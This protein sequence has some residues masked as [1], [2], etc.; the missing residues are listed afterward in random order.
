MSENTT[1]KLAAALKLKHEPARETREVVVTGLQIHAGDV[2]AATG[3]RV[4]SARSGSSK[5]I[6]KLEGKKTEHRMGID[7][8]VTVL[9]DVE[10]DE[11]REAGKA[12][13]HEFFAA[14]FLSG[15]VG[16][17]EAARNALFERLQE[18]QGAWRLVDLALDVQKAVVKEAYATSAIKAVEAGRIASFREALREVLDECT[19]ALVNGQDNSNWS[20]GHSAKNAEEQ[21][22]TEA[23]RELVRDAKW[24]I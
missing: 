7:E 18:N 14:Q 12:V 13:R 10:T 1:T 2:L 15:H 21:A 8:E 19:E 11:S 6:L 5:R 24:R 3:D 20:G 17:V 23:R 16:V 22:T 9:R 4:E